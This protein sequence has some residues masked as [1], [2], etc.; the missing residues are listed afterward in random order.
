LPACESAGDR[1]FPGEQQVKEVVGGSQRHGELRVEE[2]SI[3]EPTTDSEHGACE[4][5]AR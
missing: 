5:G 1:G 2:E 4:I 3:G